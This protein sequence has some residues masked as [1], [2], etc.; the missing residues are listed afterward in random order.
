MNEKH[1]I[2]NHTREWIVMPQDST[3]YLML[4]QSGRQGCTSYFWN[5][6]LDAWLH[7]AWREGPVFPSTCAV[8]SSSPVPPAPALWVPDAG[9]LPDP[10]SGRPVTSSSQWT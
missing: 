5:R 10:V 7:R 2:R 4:I 6:L 3:L 1:L 9:A 8:T